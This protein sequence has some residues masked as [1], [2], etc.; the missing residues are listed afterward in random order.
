MRVSFLQELIQR[1][2]GAPMRQFDGPN[3]VKRYVGEKV[4]NPKWKLFEILSR[5]LGHKRLLCFRRQY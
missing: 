1:D 3:V 2:A 5:D 4:V